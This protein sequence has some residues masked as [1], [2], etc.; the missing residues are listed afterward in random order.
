MKSFIAITIA[1][2]GMGSMQA[3]F[4]AQSDPAASNCTKIEKTAAA[5]SV[6]PQDQQT[7]NNNKATQDVV[8]VK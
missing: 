5:K 7:P 2:V 8:V 1:L 3:A 4:G 6:G